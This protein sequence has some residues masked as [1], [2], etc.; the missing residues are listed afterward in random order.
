MSGK[1]SRVFLIVLD[2]AGV[3]GAPDAAAY[4]DEGSDTIGNIARVRGGL[5]LPQ[6]GILGLGNLH[7]IEGVPPCPNPR[8]CYGRLQEQSVGKDTT[9]GHWELGGLLIEDPFPTFPDGFPEE[10]LAPFRERTG[11]GVL[12]N[13]AASGT[14]I[15][16]ELGEQ[17]Q[18]SGD[19]IVYTSADSVFQIAAH[20]EVVPVPELY[21]IC[22]TAREILDPYRV[23]R[24]IAR[25]FVGEPGA[26]QRTYNRNDYSLKPFGPTVLDRVRDAGL[27]SVGVGKIE[28]I[29]AG[30]GLTRSVHT[31]GNDDGMQKTMEL[32]DEV[33]QGLIF[34]NLVDF[35]MLWGHRNNPEGYAEGLQRFDLWLHL[36]I[37]RLRP[38]DMVALTADHGCDPTTES[39]D[40]SREHVPL[41]VHGPGLKQGVDLGT[42]QSFADLG[43]TVAEAL[44]AEPVSHGES[45][46]G[47]ILPS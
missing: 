23:G 41:I 19:L 18:Q 6:M 39:T 12:G 34:V 36:F 47:Q 42:R 31:E 26:Y 33:E 28:A 32:A 2:S 35:D 17:H 4:G 22:E 46:L 8:G 24:V 38:G 21:Q 44:G 20:E 13:K 14:V 40:H 25:P 37:K 3:G 7:R 10:I 11:R 30:Q 16:E 43:Q 9:T 29:F 45:F 27:E 1:L 5:T 15:I